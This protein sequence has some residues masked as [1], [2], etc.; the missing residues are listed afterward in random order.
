MSKQALPIHIF[1][2]GRRIT[3]T[4]EVIDYSA[5]DLAASAAAYNPKLH[6]APLVIGHP[7]TDDPAKGWV[8]SLTA[9]SRGLFALPARVD[10]AF[11]E[12][13]NTRE[14]GKVSAKFYRPNSP[15]NPVPGVWYLR[16]VGFLGAEPPAVK[17]LDDPA[18]AEAVVEDDC[19]LFQE[20]MSPPTDPMA[21]IATDPL[22][23]PAQGTV[24]PTDPASTEP[25]QEDNLV[26]KEDADKLQAENAVLAK[27]VADM[28]AAQAKSAADQRHADN[29]AFAES[30]SKEGRLKADHIPLVATVLDQLQ[31]PN[32]DGNSVEFGE[33]DAAQPLHKALRGFLS[34]LPA[35][36]EF[37]EQATASRAAADTPDEDGVMYAEGSDPE[38]IALDKKIRAHMKVNNVDYLTAARVIVK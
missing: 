2:A 11:S 17:G 30:I 27:R 12:A 23:M 36:V 1:K 22:A 7:K 24:A 18:F 13:V 4:G 34:A 8:Q 10:P 20:T 33:G 3:S 26:T 14:Y 32:G 5:S 15:H 37:S 19:V 6:E 28:E 9:T 25:N 38:R 21:D 35:S 31:I 16:H 29:V